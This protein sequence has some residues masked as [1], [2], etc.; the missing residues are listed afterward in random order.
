MSV[1]ENGVHVRIQELSSGGG[2]GGGGPGQSAKKKKDL[3]TFFFC[4]QLIMQK[5]YSQFVNF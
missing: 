2:G 1:H 4:P 5:S 3:T